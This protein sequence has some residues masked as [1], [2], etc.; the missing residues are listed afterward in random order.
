MAAMMIVEVQE[1][2]EGVH[3]LCLR[4][5]G[6]QVGPLFEHRA[7]ESFHLAVGLWPIGPGLSVLDV[8]QGGVEESAAIAA[9]VVGKDLFDLDPVF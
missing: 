2:A 3:A 8:P 6:S 9:A 7:I 5:V 4:G 1:R